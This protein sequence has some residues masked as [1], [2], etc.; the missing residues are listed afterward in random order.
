MPGGGRV[1]SGPHRTFTCRQPCCGA[2]RQTRLS[3]RP[4]DLRWADSHSAD[5][6]AVQF[7]TFADAAFLRMCDNF[8]AATGLKSRKR[9]LQNGFHGLI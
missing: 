5:K 7:S 8:F 2:A 3:P 4:Q 9:S 1:G 6:T